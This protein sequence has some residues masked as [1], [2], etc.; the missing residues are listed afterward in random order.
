[1]EGDLLPLHS[2]D[3]CQILTW[4]NNAGIRSH[5]YLNFGIHCLGCTFSGDGGH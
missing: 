4:E 1:M 3:L 2:A 5:N